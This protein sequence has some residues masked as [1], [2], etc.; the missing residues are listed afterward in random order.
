M[1]RISVFIKS[2]INRVLIC[3]IKHYLA[4]LLIVISYNLSI[5]VYQLSYERLIQNC[6]DFGM[7][8]SLY[9]NKT[10]LLNEDY[11]IDFLPLDILDIN[12][13]IPI[14]FSW[15]EGKIQAFCDI[16]FTFDNFKGYLV[17][18]LYFIAYLMMFV[19]M[20]IPVYMIAKMIFDDTYLIST[21]EESKYSETKSLKYFKKRIE[22]KLICA[23]LWCKSF[24]LFLRENNGYLW[25]LGIIWLFN[26]NL[27]SLAILILAVYVCYATTFSFGFVSNSFVKIFT[28]VFLA[29]IRI[30]LSTYFV[31]WLVIS[32][33]IKKDRAYDVLEH[34]EL[35]NRG[36]IN[37]QPLGTLICASMGAGKTTMAVDMALSTSIMFK[38]KALEILIKHDMR[39]PGFNWLRFEDDLKQCYKN[40][41]QRQKDI[42]ESGNSLIS[43][44][45]TIY[46]LSSSK[47]WVLSKYQEFTK[48]PSPDNLWGYDFERYKMTYNDDLTIS[49]LFDS[50]I[51]YSKAYLIYITQCSL[52]F[53]NLPVREDWFT[54]DGYL[55]LHI[56][57]FFHVSPEVS[58]ANSR[59][60]KIFDYDMFRL[61][62]SMV[63][64]NQNSNAFEFGVV[65][66]TEIGKERKNNLEN[67]ENKKKDDKANQNNDLFNH[68]I[69]MIRHR[70]TVDFFPFVRIISDEQRPESL[71]ADCRDTFSVIHIENK[72]ELR[73]LYTGNIFDKLIHMFV[74]PRFK[75]FYTQIRNLRGDNTLFV[76]L[77]K[78]VFHFLN[79][80][81]EKLENRFGFNVLDIELE[82]GN[83]EGQRKRYK[84]YLSHKK[85]YGDKFKTDAYSDFFEKMSLRSGRGIFDF[86]EYQDTHQTEDEMKLQNSY[87]YID[88]S[89]YTQFK[90]V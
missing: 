38:Q 42:E 20:V 52:I 72:S 35:C 33:K 81:Y 28:D 11:S 51:T 37:E 87:F 23:Y 41:I 25:A 18:L 65:V 71:G 85:I 45:S 74:W 14:D 31:T 69:K 47:Y 22:N 57:D 77:L 12:R 54:S 17:F 58:A 40:H 80:R 90:D 70:A 16:F 68:S 88:M 43:D 32:S 56:D 46:N 27:V 19:T 89:L 75:A 8:V 55:P 48:N 59:F 36:F 64:D 24:V 26:F 21:P 6:I 63:E 30:P 84:Y 29:A 53:G 60:S 67:R 5:F 4:L 9:W 86:V 82:S 39:F 7:A 15:V 83:L 78:Y 2:K 62:R 34:H 13:I 49:D 73:V 76:Y 66:L 10:V 1:K 3:D 44:T 79:N 50:L 61:G